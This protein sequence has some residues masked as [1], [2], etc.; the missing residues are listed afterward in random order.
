MAVETL[1]GREIR[2]WRALVAMWTELVDTNE[3]KP[4]HWRRVAKERRLQVKLAITDFI[5]MIQ[6]RKLLLFKLLFPWEA[7]FA[8]KKTRT[9]LYYCNFLSFPPVSFIFMSSC[10]SRDINCLCFDS[11]YL[12]TKHDLSIRH[13]LW[14]CVTFMWLYDVVV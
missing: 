8:W 3:Q 2:R 9:V 14:R 11:R 4:S 5:L 7:R 10:D 1:L 12:I 13:I 6:F